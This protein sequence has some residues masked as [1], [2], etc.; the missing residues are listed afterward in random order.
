MIQAVVF[1]LDNT[2]WDFMKAKRVAVEAAVEAMI[3][4]GL[5]LAK[6]E[7]INRIFNLY[8]VEGIEDQQIF[9]KILLQE[10]GK[11]D[12][13]ILAAGIIGYRR[14]KEGALTLYPHV[15]S[16]LMNIAKQGIKMAVISDA[17]RLAVWL[18]LCSFN[19]HPIF[20]QVI[21]FDDTGE[22]KPSP[23]PFRKLLELWPF[24]PQHVVM[25]GDW[26]ERDVVGAKQ[27]GM[28]TI[29]A[30]YGNLFETKESGA[31]HEIND[32]K[33]ILEIIKK[34]NG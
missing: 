16:T 28:K 27:V 18:R 6:E 20:D 11:I 9:D 8:S 34:E 26:A 23:K 4:A 22:R 7:M 2:L 24:D 10:F 21:T 15:M 25:V 13:K 19:L 31:D 14:A 33:E 30:C 17:P 3:D 1:D 32:I 5:D 12:Y 29:F